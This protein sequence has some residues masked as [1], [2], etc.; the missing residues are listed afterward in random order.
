MN[1]HR[2]PDSNIAPGTENR[3]AP[4]SPMAR[5]RMAA[6]AAATRDAKPK[7]AILLLDD[8]ERILN[9]LKAIFRF[10][11]QVYTATEGAQA[12]DLLRRHRIH[13][14]VSDQRMPTM[15]GVEFLR[16]AR[17]I[18]PSTVRILLTGFSDLSAIIDS[19]NDGE[20]YRFINK[21]WGNK[22]I[23]AIVDEA[24]GIAGDLA[25]AAS[26]GP[27]NSHAACSQP[28]AS[29]ASDGSEPSGAGVIVLNESGEVYHQVAATLGGAYQVWYARDTTAC[30]GLLERQEVAVL[31]AGLNADAQDYTVLFKLL[32]QEHPELLTIVM[33]ES[34]DADEVVELINQA[35]IYRYIPMPCKPARLRYFIESAVER[36][37]RYVSNPILLRQEKADPIP[38][39]SAP[40]GVSQ[41]LTRIKALRR[42]VLPRF[43]GGQT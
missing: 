37:R 22:E 5:A 2:K 39:T 31:V 18:A 23:E 36:S 9:A 25:M 43:L 12:L 7:P 29:A 40:K 13:V 34:A 38:E 1:A 42:L 11:Y 10:K 19:V 17:E 33:A 30:L 21:P 15:T 6:L 16:Q 3:A 28:A 14:V 20:V 26:A 32:K 35:K 27:A 41:M 8:E 24:V 4:L